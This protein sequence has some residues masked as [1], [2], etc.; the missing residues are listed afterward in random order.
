MTRLRESMIGGLKLRNL[1]EKDD[2]QLYPSRWR[3]LLRRTAPAQDLSF[4][5]VARPTSRKRHEGLK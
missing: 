4:P 2:H 5:L 3:L 1:S